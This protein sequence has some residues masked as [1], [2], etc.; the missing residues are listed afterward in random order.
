[1]IG[2]PFMVFGCSVGGNGLTHGRF[3]GGV[4]GIAA[5]RPAGVFMFGLAKQPALVSPSRPPRRRR[6]TA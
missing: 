5:S 4:P 6:I 2:A 3:R 1:M